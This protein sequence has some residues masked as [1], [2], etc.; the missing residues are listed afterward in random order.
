MEVAE[1]ESLNYSLSRLSQDQRTVMGK[2]LVELT[3]TDDLITL[4][5]MLDRKVRKRKTKDTASSADLTTKESKYTRPNQQC[6][7]IF[8]EDLTPERGHLYLDVEKV[9]LRLSWNVLDDER[10]VFTTRRDDG[11]IEMRR[12]RLLD[13]CKHKQVAASMAIVTEKRDIVLYAVIK[14]NPSEVCQYNT[15]I[16][17]I[18]A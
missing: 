16:S 5:N 2:Q 3:P 11:I 17:G 4:R 1:F 12:S 9:S 6:H 14:W 18:T 13:K 15:A 8:R 7:F 10:I